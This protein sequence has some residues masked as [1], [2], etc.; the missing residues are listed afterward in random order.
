MII[1][2]VS[3]VYDRKTQRLDVV[4]SD[5]ARRVYV[6]DVENIENAELIRLFH[7]LAEWQKTNQITSSGVFNGN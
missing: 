6:T 2:V 7:R 1:Q 5:G 4:L 3:A